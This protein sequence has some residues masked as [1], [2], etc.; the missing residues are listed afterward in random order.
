MRQ[1][2]FFTRQEL[3]ERFHLKSDSSTPILL[4]AFIEEQKKSWSLLNNN[5]NN[6]KK[7]L[8]KELVLGNF[9][10]KVK[11]I[12]HRIKS[13]TA[14]VDKKSIESRECFLC[15]K[16]LPKEQT[17]L[18]YLEKYVLLCN[19][20]PVFD[21]HFTLAFLNHEPQR[22][23]NHIADMINLSSEFG[24]EYLLFYNGPNCGASAPDHFHFQVCR[25]PDLPLVELIRNSFY[26]YSELTVSGEKTS[27]FVNYNSPVTHI[28]LKSPDKD[29][30]LSLFK[31]WYD[32]LYGLLPGIDEPQINLLSF[33]YA[34]NYYV[35]IFPREKH[36]PECYFKEGKD[37]LLLSPAAI[38]LSGVLIVP[39]HED[40]IKIAEP[41]ILEIYREVTASSEKII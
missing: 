40:Y 16:N 25:Q 14:P 30:T 9:R 38:D 20:Y 26:D 15:E 6:L 41:K 12:G 4:N 39:R 29:K 19:P 24:E 32:K 37:A 22:I 33:Y 27:A 21:K 34:E 10:I 1:S 3:L 36:R 18:I 11:H 13:T 28:V 7:A 5:I 23:Q 8:V 31:N 17:G 2:R 35:V